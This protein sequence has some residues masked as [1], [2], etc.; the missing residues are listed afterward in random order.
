MVDELLKE[1]FHGHEVDEVDER[2]VLEYETDILQ[3]TVHMIKNIYFFLLLRGPTYRLLNK[4]PKKCVWRVAT[5]L[6]SMQILVQNHVAVPYKTSKFQ[7]RRVAST[8]GRS[9]NAS[10]NKVLIFLIL[11]F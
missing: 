4:T 2:R 9:N 7:G 6:R 5:A 8:K 11:P 3:S 1:I 10:I